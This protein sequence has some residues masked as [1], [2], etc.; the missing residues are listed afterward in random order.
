MDR[1]HLKG[2]AGEV[3]RTSKGTAGKVGADKTLQGK[4]KSDKSKGLPEN[5][6]LHV[7]EEDKKLWEKTVGGT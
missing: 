2:A 7:N 4:E 3:K 6:N 5:S 1:K